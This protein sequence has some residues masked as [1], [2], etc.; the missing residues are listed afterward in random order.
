M[1]E[2][3][4]PIVCETPPMYVE[5]AKKF[6][7]RPEQEILF[8]WG[9]KIYNPAAIVNIPRPLIIHE[10]LHMQRQ[11]RFVTEWW[12]KYI[13]DPE[14]RLQEEIPAHVVEYAAWRQDP[15]IGRLQRRFILRKVAERLSSK[16]Y[17]NM[18]DYVGARELIR[19]LEKESRH[20]ERSPDFPR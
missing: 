1:S 11:G 3:R 15:T 16:L 10:M 2:I 18:I 7:L 9:D 5:I 17:G 19:K 20:D 4:I 12:R 8:A 13:D 6:N 14:F